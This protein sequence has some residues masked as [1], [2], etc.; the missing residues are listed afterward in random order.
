[1][2]CVCTAIELA[3]ADGMLQ[4]VVAEG[5]EVIELVERA[6]WQG[7]DRMARSPPAGRRGWSP[8]WA[9]GRHRRRR[10]P[11]TDR[12]H[13]VLR[14][15]PGRLTVR[16]IAGE[17]HVSVNT[18]KFHLRV[19]N[20]KLGVSS[21]AKAAEAA[22]QLTKLGD[23]GRSRGPASATYRAMSAVPARRRRRVG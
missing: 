11:L 17:L 3:S 2:K 16:E 6:A 21:R 15:L 22:R 9:F 12:E 5:L 18:V 14:F 7:A 19:I 4:T 23:G 13:D 20:R 1:M 10:E 8:S